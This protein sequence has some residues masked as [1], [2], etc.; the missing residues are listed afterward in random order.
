MSISLQECLARNNGRVRLLESHDL[1]SREVVRDSVGQN[2]E[3]FDGFWISSLTQTTQLGLPDTELLSP[4]TRATL[5]AY[6]NTLLTPRN[7][8][9][10]CGVFDCDSGGPLNEIPALVSVLE[11]MGVSMIIVEDKAVTEP[12]KKVNSFAESAGPGCLAKPHDFAKTLQA[13]KAA[14][15]GRNILV[16][17]RIESLTARIVIK[18]D[19]AADAASLAETM[20]DAQL[21]ARVY[22]D[23]GGADAIM[24]HSKI[25]QPT[26]VLSFLSE[27]R[28]QDSTTPI[29]LVPSAYSSASYK[30]LYEAGANVIIYAHHLFRAK[31]FALRSLTEGLSL[32][33]SASIDTLLDKKNEVLARQNELGAWKTRRLVELIRARVRTLKASRSAGILVVPE[34]K[35]TR[36]FDADEE[37]QEC[38]EARNYTAV[39]HKLM[40]RRLFGRDTAEEKEYWTLAEKAVMENMSRV[41]TLLLSGD[42]AGDEGDEFIAN[43]KELMEVN[44]KQL[45]F[46]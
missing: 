27:F 46:I 42:R 20:A 33:P 11:Q 18:N 6:Y 36:L 26:E 5:L 1:A 44:G 14:T 15:N 30:A 8:R 22:R 17:A 10:I 2:G 39:Y 29:V 32:S 40:E 3:R 24:I 41:A 34:S 16:A 4:L 28:A 35:R 9:P 38:L 31:M 25:P 43:M 21:R 19:P 13:F 12:G 23:E 37:L 7:G 45:L